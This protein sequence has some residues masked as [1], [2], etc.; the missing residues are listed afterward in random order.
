MQHCRVPA[1]RGGNTT[2]KADASSRRQS[3]ATLKGGQRLSPSEVRLAARTCL[4]AFGRSIVL[5]L[6]AAEVWLPAVI[7]AITVVI[8]KVILWCTCGLGPPSF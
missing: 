4:R 2:A 7:A 8:L 1:G 5:C 3:A 6:R